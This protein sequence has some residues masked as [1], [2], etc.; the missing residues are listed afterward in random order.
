MSK[1][2]ISTI[3]ISLCVYTAVIRHHQR[4]LVMIL[5]SDTLVMDFSPPEYR[6]AYRVSP[7]KSQNK[8]SF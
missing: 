8:I 6:M 1:I 3:I 4:A 7:T 5:P 2:G